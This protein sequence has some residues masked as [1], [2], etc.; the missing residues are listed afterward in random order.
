MLATTFPRDCSGRSTHPARFTAF[1]G[2]TLIEKIKSNKYISV[3]CILRRTLNEVV[4][5]RNSCKIHLVCEL[6]N[7]I[8][9]RYTRKLT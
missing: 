6:M 1:H 2:N 4:K 3:T 9:S 7:S 5:R 8:F